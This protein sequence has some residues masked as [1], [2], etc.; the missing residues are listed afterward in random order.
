M[1]EYNLL[2]EKWIECVDLAGKSKDVSIREILTEAHQL[3]RLANSIS[4]VNASIYFLLETILLRALTD[5]GVDLVDYEQWYQ[6][7]QTGIFNGKALNDY[8]EKWHARFFLFDDEYPFLQIKIEGECYRGSAM[9]LLPHFSGGTGGN[10]ATLFDH[11]TEDEGISLSKKEAANYLLVAHQYGVGGRVMGGDYF[12]ESLPCNG[13]S[14]FLQ[15][16]NLFETLYLNLLPYPDVAG[17]PTKDRDCPIW[18]REEPYDPAER[19]AVIEGK[20]TSY[21]PLGLLDL[22]TWPGRKIQLLLGEDQCVHEINMRSGLKMI[23]H[24]FP[25]YVYNKKGY[26]LRARVDR[27][28]WRDYAT[29]LQFHGLVTD[30]DDK[31]RSSQSLQWLHELK[32]ADFSFVHSFS[33]AALGMAKEAGKQKVYLYNEQNLPLPQ[34]YLDDENLSLD[35]AEQLNIAELIQKSL[36]GSMRSFV[37]N[38]LSFQSRN[39]DGRKPDKKDVTNLMNHLGAERFYWAELERAF[40]LL[41]NELPNDREKAIQKWQISVRSS[42]WNAFNQ[43]VALAGESIHALKAS[44]VAGGF[45]ATGLKKNLKIIKEE[46]E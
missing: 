40:T 33:L 34:E 23:P 18:E 16:V 37:E 41:V 1:S 46:M 20:K 2:E 19:S 31:S 9:K 14:F 44:I 4:L 27:A 32:R 28:V 22:L 3:K 26:D 30:E 12:S 39:E 5:A 11:H 36:Y 7:Y 43:A 15:G 35:I 8:F 10:S 25:W 13:L 38:V 17:Y 21:Q 29:L 45:L 24:P 42:A 6:G